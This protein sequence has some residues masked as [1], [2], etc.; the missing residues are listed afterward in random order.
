MRRGGGRP[1]RGHLLRP[2]PAGSDFFA[3]MAQDPAPSV[4][5]LFL[6][7]V[8]DPASF[9]A[10]AAAA[11]ARGKPVV[12]VKIGRSAAGER[13][14]RSHTASMAGWNVAYDAVFAAH[15]IIRADDPDDAGAVAAAL[16]TA[17]LAQGA[18][19]AVVTASGG[20]GAWAADMLAG[21]GL[22]PPL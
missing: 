7:S 12:A 22:S 14:A 13:A 9:L 4:I 6:E 16:A 3:H 19:V 1:C 8:R 17:P 15:G 2:P 21:A 20:A 5:L 10:A 11:A 18:R